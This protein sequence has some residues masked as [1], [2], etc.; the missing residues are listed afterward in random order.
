MFP[1]HFQLVG[2]QAQGNHIV[3]I[4]PDE[5]GHRGRIPA[6]GDG[7]H[8]LLDIIRQLLSFNGELVGRNGLVGRSVLDIEQF[9]G[10]LIVGRVGADAGRSRRQS[11]SVLG[12]AQGAASGM[13]RRLLQLGG[14]GKAEGVFHHVIVPVVREACCRQDQRCHQYRNLFHTLSVLWATSRGSA[15]NWSFPQSGRNRKGRGSRAAGRGSGRRCSRRT[16]A[17]RNLRS[18]PPSRAASSFR[19]CTL[20]GP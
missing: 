1:V 13:D 18:C 12:D 6:E 7:L 3:C 15:C 14:G 2:N 8:H 11:L 4:V 10:T 20:P 19:C 5:S 16:R 9:E 17:G